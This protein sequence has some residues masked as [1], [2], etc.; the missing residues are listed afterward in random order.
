MK[1][2]SNLPNEQDKV[3]LKLHRTYSKSEMFNYLYNEIKKLRLEKGILISENEELK[4]NLQKFEKDKEKLSL[5]LNDK[6]NE[7]VKSQNSLSKEEFNATKIKLKSISWISDLIK[8][9]SSLF[10]YKKQLQKQSN[11]YRD[12]YLSLI[13]KI[14]KEHPTFQFKFQEINEVDNTFIVEEK[15]CIYHIDPTT[16][17]EIGDWGY[18]TWDYDETFI[19]KFDEESKRIG[20]DAYPII[21]TNRLELIKDGVTAFGECSLQEIINEVENLD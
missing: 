8:S 14:R 13:A 20:I 7:L 17:I 10:K 15:G 4:Y 5:K 16:H 2:N 19:F 3:I 6:N 11:N 18:N 9:N 21:G 12:K 1:K